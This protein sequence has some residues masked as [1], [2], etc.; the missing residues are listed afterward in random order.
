MN[1]FQRTVRLFLHVSVAV[2]FDV[3]RLVRFAVFPSETVTQPVIGNFDLVTLNDFLLE[4][5]VLITD[6]ATVTRKTMRRH[7]VDETSGKTTQTAVAES[8]V[9]LFL[10]RVGKIQF[11]IFHNLFDCFVDTEIDKVRFEKTT[12]QKFD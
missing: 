6:T 7:G 4:K 5:S 9:R 8:R 12:H 10:N 11:Q 2:E 3:N 1:E